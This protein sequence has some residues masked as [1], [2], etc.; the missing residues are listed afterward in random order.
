MI[1]NNQRLETII[2]EK[3]SFAVVEAYKSARTNLLF[4]NTTDGCNIIVFTSSS[5]SEGK[6]VNCINMG[7][8]LARVGKK[9]LVIDSDMRKPQVARTLGISQAPGLSE[10][11]SGNV[12]MSDLNSIC[13][14]TKFENLDVLPSGLIPPN[15]AELISCDRMGVLINVLKEKYDYVLVD[16]PPTLVVTDSLLYR[17]YA[18]GYVLIVRA[19]KSR[20][21]NTLKL[22]N[23]LKQVDAHIIGFILN[24][25]KIESKGYGYKNYYRYEYKN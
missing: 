11:L 20:R 5:P 7:I 3:T 8:E 4:S 16:T 21:E 9:V 25:K 15:P 24:D 14:K 17:P 1:E 23:R 10:V 6:T 12:D 13:Q 22:V 19:N 18:T 2:G